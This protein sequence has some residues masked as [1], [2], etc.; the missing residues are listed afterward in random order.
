M[1]TLLTVLLL[2]TAPVRQW[3]P[4]PTESFEHPLS[5]CGSVVMA[6]IKD[7]G[8]K[9][10]TACRLLAFGIGDERVYLATIFHGRLSDCPSGCIRSHVSAAVQGLKITKIAK[11]TVPDS[12]AAIFRSAV[13]V[14]L[15]AA[16]HELTGAGGGLCAHHPDRVVLVSVGTE[17]FWSLGLPATERCIARRG[18]QPAFPVTLS[19]EVRVPITHPG[20]ADASGFTVSR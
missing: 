15:G 16:G 19:G 1:H 8:I 12:P 14:K 13:D 18:R 9:D 6:V 17:L 7:Q 2:T 5:G 3:A 20:P 4:L 10:A 11:A